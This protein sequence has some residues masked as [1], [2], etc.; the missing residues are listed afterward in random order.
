MSDDR[1]FFMSMVKQLLFAESSE[2]LYVAKRELTVMYMSNK[3]RIL[4][5]GCN[6]IGRDVRSGVFALEELL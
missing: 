5:T 4:K 6:P 2:K 1:L 3:T